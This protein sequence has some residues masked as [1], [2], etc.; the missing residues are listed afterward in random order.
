MPYQKN[1]VFP[2]RRVE[3]LAGPVGLIFLCHPLYQGRAVLTAG[4]GYLTILA[5]QQLTLALRL[6]LRHRGVGPC[7]LDVHIPDGAAY[8]LVRI[9][10]IICSAPQPQAA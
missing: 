3:L 4:G 9:R 1:V 2:G 5:A 10:N 8:N 6:R 7:R